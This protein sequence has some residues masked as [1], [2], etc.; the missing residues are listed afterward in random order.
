MSEMVPKKFLRPWRESGV[1]PRKLQKKDVT[2]E[3]KQDTLGYMFLITTARENFELRAFQRKVHFELGLDN[4]RILF[5]IGK[6]LYREDEQ[7]TRRIDEE[8]LLFQDI[9]EWNF[10]D[11][12]ETLPTKTLFR[13]HKASQKQAKWTIFQDDDVFINRDSLES[14][15]LHRDPNSEEIFCLDKMIKNGR[16]HRVGKNSLSRDQW[17][18]GFLFPPFCSGPAYVLPRKARQKILDAAELNKNMI[19][20]FPLEDVL[21]TGLLREAARIEGK[22]LKLIE[23]VAF[24]FEME[25]RMKLSQRLFLALRRYEYHDF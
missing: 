1:Q 4:S 10:I 11:S 24:H 8:K 9:E 14:A 7:I 25:K 22:E 21:F 16:A 6:G 18:V 2:E 20:H 15:L 5:L 12:Y 19:D 13:Y 23:D 17:P 3:M